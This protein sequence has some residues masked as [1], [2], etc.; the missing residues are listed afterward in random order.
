MRPDAG[1]GGGRGRE[2][3]APPHLGAHSPCHAWAEAGARLARGKWGQE[4]EAA[5]APIAPGGG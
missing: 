2:V 3:T 4:P 5:L 1:R